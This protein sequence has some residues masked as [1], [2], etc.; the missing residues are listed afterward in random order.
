MGDFK[1]QSFKPNRFLSNWLSKWKEFPRRNRK[2]HP[3]N[4]A[5]VRSAVLGELCEGGVE[6]DGLWLVKLGAAQMCHSVAT[7]VTGEKVCKIMDIRLPEQN[8]SNLRR[9]RYE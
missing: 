6:H 3:E 2:M 9:E 5:A 8:W 4:R 7:F 1:T